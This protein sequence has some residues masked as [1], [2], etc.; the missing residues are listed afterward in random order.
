MTSVWSREANL[1]MMGSEK[2]E[3]Q[4]SGKCSTGCV[5]SA[6]PNSAGSV[7]SFRSKTVFKAIPPYTSG[8][9]MGTNTS[10]PR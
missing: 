9:N 3:T 4:S 2:V 1:R 10:M 7:S 8:K 6:G 5:V